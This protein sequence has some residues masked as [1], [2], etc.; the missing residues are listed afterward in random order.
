MFQKIG[1]WFVMVIF[2]LVQKMNAQQATY[3]IFGQNRVQYAKFAWQYYDTTHFR[4]NYYSYGKY[5]AQYLLQQAELDL[6]NIVFTM[7]AKLPA[8]ID[9][10]LYN[11]YA[12]Y[13]QSNIGRYNDELNTNL[14]SV[15]DVSRNSLVVYFDGTHDGMRKQLKKG[16]AKIIRDNLLYGYSI[17][18]IV[19]N[20]ISMNLPPWYTSGYV[21][22]VS[23][24][25]NAD[26]QAAVQSW[27]HKKQ[28]LLFKDFVYL[29]PDLFG[30]SFFQFL[31]NKYSE[32]AINNLLF[33]TRFRVPVVKAIENAT[34]KSYADV[35]EEWAMYYNTVADTLLTETA[36]ARLFKGVLPAVENAVYK[37][38]LPHP[39]GN[40]IAFTELKDNE[41]SIRLWSVGNKKSAILLSGGIKSSLHIKDPNY[42]IYCWSTDGKKLAVVYE[43][44]YE[45]RLKV[46]DVKKRKAV[47]KIITKNKFERI[48]SMQFLDE[49][50]GMLVM[51]CIRK[52]QSDLFYFEI[53][54]AKL[55][56]LTKDIWDDLLPSPIRTNGTEGFLFY[57]NRPQAALVSP[58]S[59][60]QLPNLPF[61]LYYYSSAVNGIADFNKQIE[62][63]I[64][65]A[66]QYGS[67]D[68]SYL[69][70]N[71]FNK[72]RFIARH[73][74]GA[75]GKDSFVYV[76]SNATPFSVL[77]Q[78]YLPQKYTMLEIFEKAR[79]YYFYNTPIAYLDTFDKF[80]Q[81]DT[82]TSIRKNQISIVEEKSKLPAVYFLSEFENDIDSLKI[83]IPKKDQYAYDSTLWKP[84]RFKAQL[85]KNAFT[86]D[87][88]QIG[89]D[90]SL[91]FNKYQKI[92]LNGGQF[93]YPEIGPMIR[94]SLMDLMEDYK[95][96]AAVRLPVSLNSNIAY[97]AKFAN[98][99]NRVDWEILFSHNSDTF[100]QPAG[101]LISDSTF[102]SP[103]N[104]NARST[105]NYVQATF[106]Y[107]LNIVKK[108]RVE[109]GFR[110]DAVSYK[111]TS[112]YSLRF[113]SNKEY[114]WVSRAEFVHDNVIQPIK[115]IQKG[116]KYKLYSDAFVQ[117]NN[118]SGSLVTIGFDARN[119]ATLY[120]NII[121]ASR[122]AGAASTGATR[123][124]YRIGGIDN[125]VIPKS[126]NNI[127]IIDTTYKY[128]YETPVTNM[129]GYLQNSR[130]GSNYFVLNEE[131][132]LPVMNTLTKK[133]R[134]NK[135][136]QNLQLVGF[137]DMG[138]AFSNWKN[139]P[140]DYNYPFVISGNNIIVNSTQT[141]S[142]ILVGYGYGVRTE[143][144][145]YYLHADI[146]YSIDRRI[147]RISLGLQTDF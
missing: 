58:I 71:N 144:L 102:Y 17:K 22:Y 75:N 128:G 138:T 53:K 139:G 42:P 118:G 88:L 132:R 60:D 61:H 68:I 40:T 39:D 82:L 113:P 123:M 98:Y 51:S 25:W 65:N 4:I 141:S 101:T 14:N 37:N 72:Q 5:N 28:N 64:S 52:G 136:L 59:N 127:P 62:L 96:S 13:K 46:Y 38:F 29:D 121:I 44:D 69:V 131:I 86:T 143:F 23:E 106:T 92:N 32:T 33:E 56:Q 97:M 84:K 137:L 31:K 91:L 99:K 34:V 57:S 73:L 116:S 110:Q 135:L 103:F 78:F 9:V 11:S 89:L 134:K 146:G 3:E 140:Q 19:K 142:A 67:A 50:D 85:F 15:V 20:S 1:F 117:L 130:N 93:K 36:A 109:T 122:L 74:K 10:V 63:P 129:R 26:K 83:T 104:E 43:K 114:W 16:I 81:V 70:T 145:G 24:E 133:V 80:M 7:G 12:D 77:Q 120:K 107:P 41:Y 66:T 112:E 79:G 95:L 115:N 18:E 21:Q 49:D 111:A 125:E 94:L 119:Y 105:Q 8:K 54:K 35:M 90:N 55:T 45:S 124:L 27:I 47:E 147:P 30:F 2:C 76:K 6:P 48:N 126:N 87:Y 100:L 108:V